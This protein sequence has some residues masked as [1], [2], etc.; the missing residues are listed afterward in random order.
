MATSAD[1]PDLAIDPSGSGSRDELLAFLVK[2]FRREACGIVFDLSCIERSYQITRT[3]LPVGETI[4]QQKLDSVLTAHITERL[5]SEFVTSVL[6]KENLNDTEIS[7]VSDFIAQEGVG[8]GMYFISNN[9]YLNPLTLVLSDEQKRRFAELTRMP[10]VSVARLLEKRRVR[11]VRL[12]TQ[13]SFDTK[14]YIESELQAIKK[15][16]PKSPLLSAIILEPHPSRY[17]P[18]KYVGAQITGFVDG[19]GIGRYGV[20]SFFQKELQGQDGARLVKKDIRGRIIEDFD[21]SKDKSVNGVDLTLTIDHNIQK[22]VQDRLA[23]A[24]RDFGANRASAVV[25]DPRTGRVIA[26]ASAPDYDPNEY[27][28]VYDLQILDPEDQENADYLFLGLPL[29]VEDALEGENKIIDGRAIK[30]RLARDDERSNPLITKY[31]YK[32]RV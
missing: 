20:E 31:H 3:P 5:A 17:Y 11:Y 8:S 14:E 4:T 2:A 22:F 10:E 21:L 9:L 32:N 24:V 7:E 25:M 18:Q 6:V 26:M 13:I 12:L 1:L 23:R 27:G 30:L 29:F 28:R 16:D 19:Q 15:Q